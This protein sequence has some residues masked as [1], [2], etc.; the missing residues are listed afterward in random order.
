MTRT[1]EWV[2][3]STLASGQV[4][5]LP[6]YEVRGRGE[7][8][9]LGVSAAI[10]GDEIVGI[11]VIRRL[12]AFLE[13]TPLRGIVRCLPVANPLAVE[14]LTR[15]TPLAV[16]VGNLNRAFPGDAAGDLVGRLAH[17]LVQRFLRPLTHLIDLHA[18][19]THPIVD[20]TISLRD[21]EAALA[22]GQRVVRPVDGYAGTMGAVAAAEGKAAVVAEIGGGYVLDQLY[23]E[24]GLRGVVN[25]MRHLGMVDGRPERP[26][27]QWI[28]PTVAALR[29]RHGGLLYA[30][31]AP[32]QMGAELEG[33]RVLGRVRSPY[34]FEVLEELRAPFAR[35]VLVLLRPGMTRVN[36]G[37][38][39][40]MVGDL[41]GAEVVRNHA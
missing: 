7:R 14:A 40:F 20:Y 31:V 32:E 12:L 29:P 41:E 23:V 19:G 22:F 18:G 38:Y 36:P 11:E 3:V 8:P 24:V 15:G 5:R 16:E 33:G 34:T 2:E 6:I 21:L 1:V 17:L 10:H 13:C 28:V 9:V 30:E 27:E 35:S 39:A 25:V 37:D 4:L 26:A